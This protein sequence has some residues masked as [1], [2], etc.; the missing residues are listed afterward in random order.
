MFDFDIPI[1]CS[2]DHEIRLNQKMLTKANKKAIDEG[3]VRIQMEQLASQSQSYYEEKF[4][5]DPNL[6]KRIDALEAS[7]KEVGTSAFCSKFL[8]AHEGA[9]HTLNPEEFLLQAKLEGDELAD[10]LQAKWHEMELDCMLK[11]YSVYLSGLSP[12]AIARTI[13]LMRSDFDQNTLEKLDL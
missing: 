12:K 4:S 1:F 9:T 5:E 13:C 8:A 6:Q 11:F 10:G 7:I 3:L 2:F